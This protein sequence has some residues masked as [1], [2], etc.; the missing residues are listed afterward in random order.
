MIENVIGVFPLPLGIATNFKINGKD[1]LIPMAIE[2]PSVVAAAS[3]AAKLARPGGG[4]QATGS[5]PL[6]IAQIQ[7][8]SKS[9]WTQACDDIQKNK[10]Q[11]IELANV[12]CPNLKT[13]GGG[14]KDLETRII[15]TKR[16][17]MLI[18]HLIVNVGNTMGANILTRMAEGITPRLEVRVRIQLR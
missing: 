9:D 3:Y 14:A 2:E 4:F 17:E 7:L 1:F 8:V 16:G 5:E 12:I 11:L 18:V 13:Y 15:R 6:M 10:Q